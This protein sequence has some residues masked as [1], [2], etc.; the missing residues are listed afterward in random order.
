MRNLCQ[1]V[2]TDCRRIF[3]LT[4]CFDCCQK[5]CSCHCWSSAVRVV[6][7]G[8]YSSTTMQI[9]LHGCRYLGARR[10]SLFCDSGYSGWNTCPLQ[11]V[12]ADS[13]VQIP[14]AD[15]FGIWGPHSDAASLVRFAW[16]SRVPLSVSGVIQF[17]HPNHSS[18]AC[19]LFRGP[20]FQPKFWPTVGVDLSTQSYMRWGAGRGLAPGTMWMGSLASSK[21][22]R[23]SYQAR[24][25][26]YFPEATLLQYLTVC[27]QSLYQSSP[28]LRYCP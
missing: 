10:I 3:P 18:D 1:I 19:S 22:D 20:L 21:S 7:R 25:R 2:Q 15:A 9:C 17:S 23:D 16:A 11:E 5:C 13:P 26:S 27:I 4:C 6:S 12:E 14:W 28:V 24:K 8:W